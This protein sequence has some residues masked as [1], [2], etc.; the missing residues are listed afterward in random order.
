[1]NAGMPPP[2]REAQ[3]M[4]TERDSTMTLERAIRLLEGCDHFTTGLEKRALRLI[5]ANL[6]TRD[7]VVGDESLLNTCVGW[8]Q[9]VACNGSLSGVAVDDIKKTFASRKRRP[10]DMP[11]VQA[12]EIVRNEC[13]HHGPPFAAF[14][15]LEERICFDRAPETSCRREAVELL[16]SMGYVWNDGAW[17]KS[18]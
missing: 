9:A 17:K 7:A 13:A 8:V 4:T 11:L 18:G 6:V 3:A 5:K 10:V 2:P 14:K 15:A 16:L 12:V 1:M